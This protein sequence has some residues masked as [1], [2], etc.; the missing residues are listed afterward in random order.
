MLKIFNEQ[1]KTITGAAIIIAGATLINKFVGLARD[2]AIAHYFGAG[3]ITDA[4]YAAFKIPDFIYTL[5]IVGALTA[6]FIPIFTKLTLRP[7]NKAAAWRLSSNIL[8]ILFFILSPLCIL[9]M[10]FAP[11]I[12]GIVGA[13]FD[14]ETIKLVTSFTRILFISPIFL[15]MSMVMGGILQSQRH[16]TLYSI[17]PIFYNAGIIFGITVLVPSLGVTGLA[18]GVIVGAAA[19]FTIQFIG[20]RLAGFR[21]RW[22]IDWTDKETL[23]VGR[24]MIPRSLGLAVSQTFAIITTI[25]AS[26]LPAG[27]VAVFAF[28][29]N[30]RTVPVGIIGTSFAIAIF[31]TL[32]LAAAQNNEEGFSKNMTSTIRQISFL[33]I[34]SALIFLLLRV[35]IVRLML[36]SGAFDRDDTKST[37][38][39][40][41]IFSF[42]MLADCFRPILVRGFF[43][44]SDTKTPLITSLISVAIGIS[45]AYWLMKPYG[46]VGLAMANVIEGGLNVSLLTYLL[47][48][49]NKGLDL[50]S[51]FSA[52]ARILAA[53]VIAG[54]CI[55]WSLRPL[56]EI[57]DQ[58]YF[59]G[60]FGQGF[61]AGIIGLV[62]YGFLC[63]IFKLPELYSVAD[64]LHRRWLKIK[65]IRNTELFET[66]E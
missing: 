13:G 34:P 11:Q 21:W 42:S 18:W 64:S 14:L 61:T 62:I 51:I 32:S 59:L 38:A 1:S 4:Y 63:Y 47:Q 36:G 19:H 24:L 29:D 7:D 41:M 2:R 50:S 48:R 40:L 16:F 15:G 25:L 3:P 65:N 31:P 58:S 53:A 8:N 30:L 56:A 44:L 27:S 60:V 23:A 49:K 45:S 20:A 35:Q 33:I 17:A 9:G 12:A 54:F 52:L 28:A 26:L 39:A 22:I 6:G 5:L 43:A 37:A 66:K 10:I 46:I 55:H 57:F